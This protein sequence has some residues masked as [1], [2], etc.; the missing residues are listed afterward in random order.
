MSHPDFELFERFAK[1]S[2]DLRAT[3]A[4]VQN[5]HDSLISDAMITA[6]DV[7]RNTRQFI[8][9]CEEHIAE[10]QSLQ[11]ATVRRLEAVLAALETSQPHSVEP[12]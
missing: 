5:D 8:A 6:D 7:C 2:L 9:R 12:L 11:C 1:L 10:L 3:A 4:V